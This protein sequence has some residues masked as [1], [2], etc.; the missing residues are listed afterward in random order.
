VKCFDE[1]FHSRISVALKYDDLDLK[2]R[3]KI[4]VNLL[5]AA[6]VTGIET[7][8]MAECEL[9]GRQIRSCIRL[10]ESLAISEGIDKVT[11]EHIARCVALAKVGTLEFI[12]QKEIYLKEHHH[13]NDKQT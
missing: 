3:H 8:K 2:A 7:E 11:N 5:E 4:W 6:G 1:A 10:A 12:K 13:E 9:N